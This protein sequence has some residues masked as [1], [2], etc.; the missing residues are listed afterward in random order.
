MPL[1]QTH[2]TGARQA[3]VGEPEVVEDG[4]AASSTR[5]RGAR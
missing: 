1:S 4:R 5:R 3:V 2:Q